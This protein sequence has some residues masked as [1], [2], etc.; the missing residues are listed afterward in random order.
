D[1]R[2]VDSLGWVYFQLGK[3]KTALQLL[4]RAAELS[5][6]DA[7][8]RY[9]L[10]RAFETLGNVQAARVEYTKTLWLDPVFAG[11]KCRIE[12]PDLE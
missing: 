5:P 10:G 6:S 11:A 1:G 8:I 2:F 12:K 9:H 3:H 7:E 4:A